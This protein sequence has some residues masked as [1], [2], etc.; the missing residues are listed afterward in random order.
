MLSSR[1]GRVR[2]KRFLCLFFAIAALIS[3]MNAP[4]KVSAN[5][6]ESLRNEVLI[7]GDVFGTRISTK[8]VLVVGLTAVTSENKE[9]FPARDAGICSKDIINRVNGEEAVSSEHL[10]SLIEKSEGR[11]LE[12][13][14]SRDGE[15]MSVMLSPVKSDSD[16]IY[17]AGLWVRDSLAGIGTITFV[18]PET[19]EFAGLGHGMCDGDTGVIMPVRQGSVFRVHL[20]EIKKSGSGEPGELRGRLDSEKIGEVTK[21]SPSGVYGSLGD[22]RQERRALVC[23]KDEVKTGGV[24]VI[25]TI[26]EN[27]PKEYDAV[28]EKIC[29]ADG[30]TKNF[31]IKIT[32]SAL[33]SKT[34]GIVQGMSGSPI[35]QNG[36]LIGAV[37]HVLI[38]DPTKGYGIFAENMLENMAMPTEE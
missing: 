19:R 8:G 1:K 2:E 18:I 36:K 4:Y 25:C 23:D 34:G 24:T 29:D 15:E 26:D 14:F 30:K 13:G 32:D 12:I 6:N 17:R 28:I 5:E 27:G 16:G 11:P 9:R 10:V 33:L 7:G 31:I 22:L 37:T 21:N 3:V 20:G 38:D 35:L